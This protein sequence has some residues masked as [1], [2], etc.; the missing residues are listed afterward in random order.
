MAKLLPTLP[1]GDGFNMFLRLRYLLA[2]IARCLVFYDRD[3]HE[4]AQSAPCRAFA[5]RAAEHFFHKSR[6]AAI[7]GDMVLL[8]QC[9]ITIAPILQRQR[10]S[11]GFD[12]HAG[13]VLTW[14]RVNTASNVGRYYFSSEEHARVPDPLLLRKNLQHLKI[15]DNKF[16]DT[17]EMLFRAYFG[18]KSVS[19]KL[20]NTL[21]DP[22]MFSQLG[23]KYCLR[24]GNKLFRL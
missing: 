10:N 21:F 18:R 3:L 8:F 1:P 7:Y 19:G 16:N 9:L 11:M 13:N 23:D 17:L 14:F 15:C 6:L 12:W 20:A 5:Y 22:I 4:V 24:V 2:G